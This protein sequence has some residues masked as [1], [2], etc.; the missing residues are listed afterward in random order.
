MCMHVIDDQAMQDMIEFVK[1]HHLLVRQNHIMR[2]YVDE[3]DFMLKKLADL[4]QRF[5]RALANHPPAPRAP[6]KRKA[7]P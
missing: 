3:M 1:Q 6:R 4:A 2:E 5:E 7:N